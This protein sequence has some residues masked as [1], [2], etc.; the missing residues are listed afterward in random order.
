MCV[1]IQAVT[2]VAHNSLRARI[3]DYLQAFVYRDEH[4]DAAKTVSICQAEGVPSCLALSGDVACPKVCTSCFL[5]VWRSTE[6]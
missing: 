5:N 3:M 6:L 2:A 4:E 1:R